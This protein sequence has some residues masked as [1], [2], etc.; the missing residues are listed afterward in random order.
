MNIEEDPEAPGYWIAEDGRVRG[1][2]GKWLKPLPNTNGYARFT[3]G[4]GARGE[5]ASRYIHVA[6][7]ATYH[8]PRPSPK[9]MVR[10][11][12]GDRLDNRASNLTWGTGVENSADSFRHGTARIGETHHR[13]KLTQA[14]VN[15]IKFT[16][17]REDRPTLAEMAR[18]YGVSLTCISA[19]S[20]GRNWK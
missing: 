19:I 16:L 2:S 1:P 18:T 12:N 20:T 9:H 17:S 11:L 7:C 4:L 5:Q 14:Q 8:G 15:E 6:V 10:H 13:A 3:V